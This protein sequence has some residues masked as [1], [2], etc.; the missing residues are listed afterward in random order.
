MKEVTNKSTGS[1][2]TL[3]VLEARLAVLQ[4][5]AKTND[6]STQLPLAEV[7]KTMAEIYFRQSNYLESGKLYSQA[8]SIYAR[9]QNHQGLIKCQNAQASICLAKGDLAAAKSKLEGLLTL[10]KKHPDPNT[11]HI[12]LNN[13]GI[14]HEKLS[15]LYELL[16]EKYSIQKKNGFKILL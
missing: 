15:P 7:Y 16:L 5:T 3:T 11:E 14:V 10:F 6:K 4:K 12:V 13:I 1:Y 9:L 2:S 8:L